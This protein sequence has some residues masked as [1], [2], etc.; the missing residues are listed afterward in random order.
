M[1]HDEN[2]VPVIGTRPLRSEWD[3][4]WL[5]T[6]SADDRRQGRR[7][8][9]RSAAKARRALSTAREATEARREALEVL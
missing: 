8:D 4:Q 2:F 7:Q 1:R 9:R 5:R 6:E 3:E